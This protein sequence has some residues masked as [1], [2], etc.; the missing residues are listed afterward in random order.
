MVP[1]APSS[2]RILLVR[3]L[4]SLAEC[5]GIFTLGP[6]I[7]K[8]AQ[9]S[10][11][12][13]PGHFQARISL[14]AFITRPQAEHQIGASSQ[15]AGET[16]LCQPLILIMRPPHDPYRVRIPIDRRRVSLPGALGRLRSGGH[17]FLSDLLPLDGRGD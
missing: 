14:A 13:G 6:K 8:P 17:H 10:P 3:R 4:A 16:L 5:A 11:E 9:L 1:M 2:I 15:C 12:T 7:K